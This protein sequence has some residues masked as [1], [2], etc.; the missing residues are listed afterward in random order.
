MANSALETELAHKFAE[1][2]SIVLSHDRSV[3]AGIALSFLPI[4]PITFLGFIICGLNYSLWKK[5]KL[6]I[7]E[8][9]AIKI[10][11]W[12]GLINTLFGIFIVVLLFNIFLDMNWHQYQVLFFEY[13]SSFFRFVSPMG[14]PIPRNAI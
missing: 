14:T 6:D 12:I 3:I 8:G 4:F 5:G 7:S 10:G 1:F 2:R 11:L 9:R 13:V